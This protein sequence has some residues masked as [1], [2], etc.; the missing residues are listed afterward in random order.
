MAATVK[1]AQIKIDVKTDG[2]APVHV[3]RTDG[4]DKGDGEDRR[5][6]IFNFFRIEVVE[7]RR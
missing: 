7:Q 4:K 3:I 5:L 1:I 2:V 6:A